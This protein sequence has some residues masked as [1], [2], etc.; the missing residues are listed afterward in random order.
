[1]LGT[2]YTYIYDR[3]YPVLLFQETNNKGEKYNHL[4]L[5]VISLYN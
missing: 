1:M 5:W 4:N 2:S 3:S